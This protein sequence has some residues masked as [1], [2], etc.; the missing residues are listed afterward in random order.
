MSTRPALLPNDQPYAL[1]LLRAFFGNRASSL[2]QQHGGSLAAL[3]AAARDSIDP[4]MRLLNQAHAIAEAAAVEIASNSDALSSPQAVTHFLQLRFAGAS[5]ESFIV[6][7]L[8]TANHLIAAEEMFRGTLS[9]TSVYP[10]EVVRRALHHN[11]ASIICSHCHPSG[12]CEPSRADEYLTQSL[13][14]ALQLIDVRVLDHILIAG[15]TSLSFAQRGI[16]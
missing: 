7:H 13:K 3:L 8:D 11:A 1:S 5:A 9:Q 10:R 12:V 14:Q 4:R 16:L 2:L 15:G 6:L